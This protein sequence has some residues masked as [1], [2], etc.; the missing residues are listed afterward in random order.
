MDTFLLS[1]R[2][3]G[4]LSCSWLVNGTL[5]TS[6]RLDFGMSHYQHQQ[7]S[8]CFVH[9][10]FTAWVFVKVWYRHIAGEQVQSAVVIQY[11][12]VK[13]C[14]VRKAARLAK[15]ILLE[16]LDLAARSLDCLVLL[17]AIASI[18]KVVIGVMSRG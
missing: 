3:L 10:C 18:V 15:E 12:I 2:A 4:C 5:H 9:Q 17:Q 1:L 14:R 11:T 6:T 7:Y 8:A 16:S 13:V